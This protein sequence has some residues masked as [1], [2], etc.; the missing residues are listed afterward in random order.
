MTDGL[1]CA[2]CSCDVVESS[3]S[4]G[5]GYYCKNCNTSRRGDSVHYSKCDCCNEEL[6]PASEGAYCTNCV[7]YGC[8]DPLLRGIP[9]CKYKK[10]T[11]APPDCDEHNFHLRPYQDHDLECAYCGFETN[12]GYAD[13]DYGNDWAEKRGK[14]LERDNKTCQ[15][16]GIGRQEHQEKYDSDLH[17]HHI[18]PLRLHDTAAE[19]NKLDNLETLCAKCHHEHEWRDNR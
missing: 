8:D 16:C 12:F 11:T 6:K 18:K 9:D 5:V 14:A 7:E 19:A 3:S 4:R 13:G 2:E 17:V 1:I 15:S 10:D